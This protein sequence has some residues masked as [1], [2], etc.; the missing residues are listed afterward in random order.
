MPV[1]AVVGVAFLV[2]VAVVGF[3]AR[4]FLVVVVVVEGTDAF[5]TRPE[6]T[7]LDDEERGLDVFAFVLEEG[8]RVDWMV[9]RR[10]GLEFP[11]VFG[12]SCAR[13]REGVEDGR[14][15]S[16]TCSCSHDDDVFNK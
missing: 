4:D 9:E 2:V 1:V 15:S 5:P 6:T 12:V 16:C 11:V 7:L 3:V 13:W 8:V 10:R 14:T